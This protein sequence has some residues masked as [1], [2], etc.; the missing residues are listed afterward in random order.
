[1]CGMEN[2][3][4]ILAVIYQAAHQQETWIKRFPY[5][6]A[7][8][9]R[10][11]TVLIAGALLQNYVWRMP[12]VIEH[13]P[14]GRTRELRLV[15]DK[16]SSWGGPETLKWQSRP[17]TNQALLIILL[18]NLLAILSSKRSRRRLSQ[19]HL[20]LACR[21]PGCLEKNY[22]IKPSHKQANVEEAVFLEPDYLGLNW[23]LKAT[24]DPD[25]GEEVS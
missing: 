23:N 7:E 2:Y 13:Q 20:T 11:L 15:A 25:S 3:Q 8:G 16:I 14:R 1:M 5:L 19:I 22:K 17:Y 24:K 12:I 10:A 4:P 6:L 18:R 21:W 9:H